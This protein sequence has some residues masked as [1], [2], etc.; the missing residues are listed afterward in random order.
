MPPQIDVGNSYSLFFLFIPEDLIALLSV[1]INKYA[2]AKNAGQFGRD[3]HKTT[4]SEIKIF[5]AIINYMGVHVSHCDEDY[6]QTAEEPFHMPRQ[7][8]D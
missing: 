7:F 6:W 4:T 3:W 8:M 5:L 1:N 2:K